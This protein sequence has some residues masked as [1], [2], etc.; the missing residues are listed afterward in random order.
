MLTRKHFELIA[1]AIRVERPTDA[2]RYYRRNASRQLAQVRDETCNAI[3]ENLAANLAMTN[4][5]F[6]RERFIQATRNKDSDH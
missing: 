4:P 5:S 3:A 2:Q 1:E 6:D